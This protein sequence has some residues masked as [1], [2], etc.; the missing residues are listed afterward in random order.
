[1]PYDTAVLGS[2][3]C[4]PDPPLRPQDKATLTLR[5]VDQ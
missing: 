1:V 5:N 4:V 3:T 2:W